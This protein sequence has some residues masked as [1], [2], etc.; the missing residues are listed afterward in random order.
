MTVIEWLLVA[1]GAIIVNFLLAIA[2]GKFLKARA[3][4]K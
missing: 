2:I 1:V 4:L 3:R